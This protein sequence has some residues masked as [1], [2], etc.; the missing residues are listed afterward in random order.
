MEFS[1]YPS[2]AKPITGHVPQVPRLHIF[3]GAS[4]DDDSTS[5]LA[6]CANA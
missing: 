6:S 1:C 5:A 3:H 4:R 2:I